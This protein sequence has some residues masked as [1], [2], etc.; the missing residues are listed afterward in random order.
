M[1]CPKCGAKLSSALFDPDCY[2]EDCGFCRCCHTEVTEKMMME[3]MDPSD[4]RRVRSGEFTE[5]EF[6][7][8]CYCGECHD[9]CSLAHPDDD[10]DIEQDEEW[11]WS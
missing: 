5:D 9:S 10:M 7:P 6:D 1:R 3:Y 8:Q 4:C 11:N 2:W